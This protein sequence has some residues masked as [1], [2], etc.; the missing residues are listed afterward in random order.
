[1]QNLSLTN[2]K[3]FCRLNKEMKKFKFS[4]LLIFLI[5]FSLRI[6]AKDIENDALLDEYSGNYEN[7]FCNYLKIVEKEKVDYKRLVYLIRAF[8]ILDFVKNKGIFENSLKKL[9]DEKQEPIFEFYLKYY[10]AKFYL[11]YGKVKEAKT[12]YQN[13]G[14]VDEFILI[15]PFDNEGETGFEKVYPPENEIN[16]EKYYSGKGFDVSWFENKIKPYF[17]YIYLKS[18]FRPDK[19]VCAYALTYLYSEKDRFCVLRIGSDEG[20]K[21][22]LNDILIFS[23]NATRPA[24]PDQDSIL[25]KLNKGWNKV[26][27][28]IC[29]TEE[30]WGFFLRITEND[31][32]PLKLKC[33]VTR[34]E[35]RKVK[36]EVKIDF[37]SQGN[38]GIINNLEKLSE[39]NKDVNLKIYLAYLYLKFQPYDKEEKREKKILESAVSLNS[40]DFL[41]Y[42]LLS[43]A[44][45][46]ENKKR[47]YLEKAKEIN[48]NDLKAEIEIA[49][50]FISKKLF[51]LAEERLNYV[52]SK[53]PSHPEAIFYKGEIFHKRGWRNLA[54]EEFKKAIE[55]SPNYSEAN[56]FFCRYLKEDFQSDP[57]KILDNYYKLKNINFIYTAPREEL[58]ELL[59]RFEKYDEAIENYEEVI[60]FSPYYIPAYQ[61]ISKVYKIRKDYDKAIYYLKKVLEFSP[62]NEEIYKEIGIC[63]NYKNEKENAIKFLEKSIALKPDPEISQYLSYLSP[64][65][66]EFDKEFKE[67]VEK[68]IKNSPKREDYPNCNAVYLLDKKVRKVNIDGTSSYI[69]HQII[70]VFTEEGIKK[71]GSF[72][73]DFVKDYE[74]VEIREARVI[75]KDG[76]EM[77]ATDIWETGKWGGW[78]LYY[79]FKSKIIRMPGVEE[80][81]IIE[82]EY[83][84]DVKKNL[85]ADYFGEIFNLSNIEPT[86]LL[87]YILI[88]PKKRDFYFKAVKSEIKP[89]IIEKEDTKVYIW[90]REN[91]EGVEEE[92]DMPPKMEIIPYLQI[93]TFKK[94]DEM[95]IWYWNLIKDQFDTNKDLK[96]K[97][98]EI[99]KNCK[100]EEEK[101]REIYNFVV[102]KIRYLGIEFGIGGWKPR[103][104]TE[105]FNTLYGDCKD[106]ATL[107]ISMFKELETPAKIVLIPTRHLGKIDRE[108]SLIDQFNHAIVY[109]NLQ[110]KEIFLDGTAEYHSFG[111]LPFMDQGTEV[112]VMDKESYQFKNTELDRPEKNLTK[113]TLKIKISKDGSIEGEGKFELKGLSQ[114]YPRYK[115]LVEGKRKEELE[116]YLNSE[117]GFAGVQVKEFK[118]SDLKDLNK[119]V[120]YQVKFSAKDFID[121]KQETPSFYPHLKREELVKSYAI[122]ENRDQKIKFIWDEPYK[123]EE[124]IEIEI[125]AEYRIESMPENF[126]IENEF[127]YYSINFKEENNKILCKKIFQLNVSEVELQE[128]KDFRGT[129]LKIDDEEEGR[130]SLKTSG[131]K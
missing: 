63:Y 94:W 43:L 54:F 108:L 115:Y 80:D 16:F 34:E 107:I 120:N 96:N 70:K 79:D 97:I 30:D 48:D 42:H 59:L 26:L 131:V 102:T 37:T 92:P 65:K 119:D 78:K 55:V 11:Q 114:E 130:V 86:K 81:S 123:I 105:V 90:K 25:V 83:K 23:K 53:N 72:Y 125:P 40:Q 29:Q 121:L 31:G 38:L 32:T 126:E 84:I 50:I 8:E 127:C 66:E 57:L 60:N 69:V 24:Y 49:K 116:K 13:L 7:A 3:N 100:T 82:L 5:L 39:K 4:I 6:F 64:E 47:N 18:I 104:A 20:I 128:Y 112:L 103:K 85:F 99:T 106:K 76:K 52:L 44:D 124:E 17:G 21:L 36:K 41:I 56:L 9:L 93:T 61:E 89:E 35:A 95:H 12:L 71:F 91:V 19:N 113:L 98:M 67:D 87:K 74:D 110:G 10:L 1:M 117:F 68:I 62:Y 101:I 129:L 118:F 111:T 75:R 28:K 88:F 58:F 73:I 46:D 122:K 109:V 51:A 2:C 45:E 77:S 33:K 15:G 14:F 27:L 22:W